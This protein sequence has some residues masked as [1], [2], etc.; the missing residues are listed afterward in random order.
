MTAISTNA[1]QTEQSEANNMHFQDVLGRES[2]SVLPTSELQQRLLRLLVE[3]KRQN[4]TPC[5]FCT[6]GTLC[7][8]LFCSA[9][10][11]SRGMLVHV[12]ICPEWFPTV[13]NSSA[14]ADQRIG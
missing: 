13:C 3:K 2:E 11:Y 14:Q 1:S 5:S 4:K 6:V 8:T 9:V 7:S 10:L 12:K